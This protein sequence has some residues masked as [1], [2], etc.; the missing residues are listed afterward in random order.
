[1]KKMSVKKAPRGDVHDHGRHQ[2]RPELQSGGP[3]IEVDMQMEWKVLERQPSVTQQQG[4]RARQGFWGRAQ[5]P[6]VVPGL[7]VK[8][9]GAY[10]Y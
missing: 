9:A 4:N 5:T 7:R 10:G 1:M 2:S 3:R 6:S 8:R